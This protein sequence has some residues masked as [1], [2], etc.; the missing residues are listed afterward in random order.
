MLGLSFW[1]QLAVTGAV[2][3]VTL[4]LAS[5]ALDDTWSTIW[6]L[7][8]LAAIAYGFWLIRSGFDRL[9]RHRQ[10]HDDL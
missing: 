6:F 10:S 2:G 5:A 4:L 7:V 3:V 1:L 8:F 9:D